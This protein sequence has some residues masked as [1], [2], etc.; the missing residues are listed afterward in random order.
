MWSNIKKTFQVSSKD[1]VVQSTN[2]MSS[3]DADGKC[4]GD[5]SIEDSVVMRSNSG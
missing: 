4:S 3:C 5:V 1:S 2:L